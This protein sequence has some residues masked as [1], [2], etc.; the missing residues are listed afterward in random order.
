MNEY[1]NKY[2]GLMSCLLAILGTALPWSAAAEQPPYSPSF[3]EVVDVRVVNLEAVVTQK[4]RRVE[5]L[6]RDSFR[7]LVDGREVPIEYF[8]EVRDRRAVE[9]SEPSAAVPALEPGKVLGTRYL[10]FVDDYFAVPAYR[11]QALRELS[12][13]LSLLGPA[14]QMA[15]VAFNGRRVEMLSSWTRSL[16]Q[17]SSALEAA[18]QR[19]AFGLQRQSEQRR[20]DT[21]TRLSDRGGLRS[22]DSRFGSLSRSG[23]YPYGDFDLAYE[24]ELDWQVSRVVQGATSALRAFARPPG[25]KVMLLLSGGWPAVALDR[26]ALAGYGLRDPRVFDPLIDT[27]NRLGYTLYPV[28]LNTESGILPGNAEYGSLAEA[29]LV[30]RRRQARDGWEEDAL[31]YLAEST[32]GR[33]AIDGARD[34]ALERVV[35]DTRSFYWLG[36]SPTWEQNDQRHQVKL[37]MRVQGLKARTRNSFSDLSRQSEITMMVESAQLFELPLPG[38]G[39]LGVSFGE[40]T[41]AGFKKVTLPVRLEIPLDRISLLPVAGGYAASLELRVAATDDDGGSSEIPIVPVEL[42]GD[43]TPAAGETAVFETQLKLRTKPHRLVL[44][45]YDPASG[46]LLS[47]RVELAL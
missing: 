19:T 13:Q 20:V 1:L 21:L 23:L 45:L 9:S 7:L 5:G 30:S 2:Q 8:T 25:R 36:F 14:D 24:E 29:N 28:D 22:F 39:R 44:S 4:G 42:R 32:G 12:Q 10:V 38:Q 16:M 46:S 11:N 17:L 6:G 43:G 47:E 15:I 31:Y 3:G 37:E 35:E 27:A 41:K 40:P 18:R 33:A 34:R 26:T